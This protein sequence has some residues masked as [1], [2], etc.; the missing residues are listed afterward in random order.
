MPIVRPRSWL[1]NQNIHDDGEHVVGQVDVVPVLVEEGADALVLHLDQ[2]ENQEE[3]G[4]A[5]CQRKRHR[6]SP[7]ARSETP[8]NSAS[9]VPGAKALV[10]AVVV[11]PAL[12]VPHR[13][14][15]C[16]VA[17]TRSP[18][19]ALH[20]DIQDE[21]GL[22]KRCKNANNVENKKYEEDARGVRTPLELNQRTDRVRLKDGEVIRRLHC[23]D[24]QVE[25][26]V[27]HIV[28]LRAA[29]GP[30]AP[31]HRKHLDLCAH[32]GC[33]LQTSSF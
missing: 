30:S 20:E 17:G 25:E 6:N 18:A 2:L 12:S 31:W 15:E 24:D 8:K 10:V 32:T 14:E 16:G 28:D 19:K 27:L 7:L 21:S 4:S 29:S 3:P 26:C 33:F 1:A 9:R 23:N 22:D 13:L 11:P 5:A